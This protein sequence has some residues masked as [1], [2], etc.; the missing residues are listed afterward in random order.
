MGTFETPSVVPND[1]PAGCLIAL[2]TSMDAEA[3]SRSIVCDFETSPCGTDM[4]NLLCKY[5]SDSGPGILR[6]K[7]RKRI[8]AGG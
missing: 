6:R 2:T 7:T 3:P 4:L 8:K 1:R 5:S